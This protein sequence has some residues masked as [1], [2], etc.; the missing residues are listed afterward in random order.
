MSERSYWTT[1]EIRKRI[2][3][4][5]GKDL[6]IPTIHRYMR[7]F[8][9]HLKKPYT[10][11]YRRP[12]NAEGLLIEN[13]ENTVSKI[14]SKGISIENVAIG[15]L[16][17][18]YVQSNPNTVRF[19]TKLKKFVKRVNSD[20]TR[21]SLL[22]FYAFVGNDVC[23]E[24]E[25][26][27]K[28]EIC[29]AIKKIKEENSKYDAIIIILDNFPSHKSKMVKELAE[30][31]NVFLVYLPPYSP[32]LNPIEFIW[33]CLKRFI[34]KLS[35]LDTEEII[36]QCINEYYKL[37]SKLSYSKKFINDILKN[38]SLKSFSKIF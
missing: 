1:G 10:I 34:S 23:I 14:L 18:T 21:K 9:Y 12:E 35:I 38:T 22:G 24:I 8:G 26:S 28:F 4:E 27:G 7:K 16:D 5:F 33:K 30:E 29:K 11:D 37:S 6:S 36:K 17:E 31:L 15:F 2:M 20:K 32:D 3:D 19:W 13:L 25:N